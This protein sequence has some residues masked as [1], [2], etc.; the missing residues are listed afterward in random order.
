MMR[1]YRLLTLV[2]FFLFCLGQMAGKAQKLSTKAGEWEEVYHKD[3]IQI[4]DRWITQ[5]HPALKFRERKGI[6]Q[7]KCNAE[8]AYKII[9]DS[10]NTKKWMKGVSICKDYN[11]NENTW[12]TYTLYGLPWPFD[13]RELYSQLTASVSP[14]GHRKIFIQ[15]IDTLQPSQYKPLKEFYSEWT[16]KPINIHYSE[17]TMVSATKMPPVIPLFLQDP[18]LL[19]V[20]KENLI[21]LKA[22]L[23]NPNS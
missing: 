19:L 18:I 20:Y 21:R 7:S 9:A 6:I 4:I 12:E 23:E 14:E 5:T 2:F 17:I 10:E 22:L 16:I 13:S 8:L 3:G 11:R 15:S 1:I